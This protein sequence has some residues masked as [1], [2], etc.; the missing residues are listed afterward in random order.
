MWMYSPH[1]FR[2]IRSE[3]IRVQQCKQCKFPGRI[4]WMSSFIYIISPLFAS[5]HGAVPRTHPTQP[6]F[7]L[8]NLF[9]LTWFNQIWKK[10]HKTM[11][12]KRSLPTNSELMCQTYGYLKGGRETWDESL[13]LFVLDSVDWQGQREGTNTSFVGGQ[14]YI[15]SC[16]V[17]HSP[18]S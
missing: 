5:W 3:N 17:P 12:H 16:I 1:L 7:L 4:C 9:D 2:R 13:Q 6:K 8:K 18:N 15:K 11:K 10:M 14:Q